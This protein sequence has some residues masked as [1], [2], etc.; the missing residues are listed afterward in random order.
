M[1][2]IIGEK[3]SNNQNFI[4]LVRSWNEIIQN[5]RMLKIVSDQNFRLELYG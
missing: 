3:A 2:R 5:R 1:L 4:L